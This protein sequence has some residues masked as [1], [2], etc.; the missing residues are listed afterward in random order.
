[1]EFNPVTKKIVWE[2]DWHKNHKGMLG[3]MD[4]KF[5]SPFVSYAQ[6]LPNGNTM[7]TEGDMA[8]VFELTSSNE[9]VWEYLCPYST[10]TMDILY[11]S[12]RIGY[13]WAPEARHAE[14]VNVIPPDNN[15]FYLPN[16]K[17]EYPR[18]GIQG[19]T[20]KASLTAA[21][22]HTEADE[23]LEEDEEVTSMHSY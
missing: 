18:T 2:Y 21:Q 7:I 22:T 3:H 4:F 9:L 6:R 1:M 16:A 15:L 8:R 10:E 12:Y 20:V 23:D 13:E 17:G 14:E 5:F 19:E 11:R